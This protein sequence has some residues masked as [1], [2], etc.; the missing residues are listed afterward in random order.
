MKKLVVSIF[1]LACAVQLVA[2]NTKFK[3]TAGNRDA[4]NTL[5]YV[6]LKKALPPNKTSA[7]DVVDDKTGARYPAQFSDGSTLVFKLTGM[8]PAGKTNTYTIKPADTKLKAGARIE[9]KKDGMLIT[10]NNRPVFFYNTAVKNPP[11]GS[12]DYYRRSGFIHPLYSPDGSVLTDDFPAGHMH[13]HGIFL[14]W[15]NTT[16][17]GEMVDFWNQH[18]NTGT[19]EHVEVL[20]IEEGP[21]F[22]RL[23]TKLRH[24]SLKHGPV[25]EEV[26]TITI[27]NFADHYM[28][29]LA[30]E[31]VNITADTLYINKYQYGGLAFRGSREWN[32]HDSVH[33]RNLWQVLTSE[34][35]DTAD[36]NHT[37][38]RWVDASGKVNGKLNGVTILADVGNFRYPQ[39]IRV[40]PD[41]PYWCFAPMV[42]G[43]FALVPGGLYKSRYRFVVHAGQPDVKG[44]ELKWKDWVNP[45][46]GVVR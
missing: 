6:S 21:V 11:A 45:V 16:F 12:P 43:A 3:V 22:S 36:A 1:I 46:R 41:M 37:K 38:A 4:V 5:V 42:D 44:I 8:L 24:I 30:S 25:L 29:D 7:Y 20:G 2:Q 39:S 34:G 26:W 9:P 28:F 31:Q 27:Y 18:K 33:F 35:K 19:V 14:T 17:R 32:R 15:V 23:K 40:H 10:V 13:Q